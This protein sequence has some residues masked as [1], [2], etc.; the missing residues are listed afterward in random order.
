MK[1]NNPSLILQAMISITARGAGVVLNFI[2]TVIL[3][4]NLPPSEAGMIQTLIILLTGI[5]LFSRLGV[6]HWLVRDVAR[7][8]DDEQLHTEQGNFLHSAYRMLSLVQCCLCWAGC[9]LAP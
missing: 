4:R 6:E 8:P 5:S 3:T 7:L 1:L 9:C 2:V